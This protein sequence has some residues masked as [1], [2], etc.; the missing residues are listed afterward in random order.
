[1]GVSGTTMTLPDGKSNGTAS[2]TAFDFSRVSLSATLSFLPLF[3][4][5]RQQTQ[6]QK[7]RYL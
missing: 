4:F 7:T 1:M 5:S 6:Q 2:R 3:Q